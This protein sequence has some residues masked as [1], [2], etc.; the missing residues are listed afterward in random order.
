MTAQ[1]QT[2]HYVETGYV[3]GWAKDTFD[4]YSYLASH[5]DLLNAFGSNGTAATRHYAMNGYNAGRATDNF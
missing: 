4:E 5:I 1:R 2:Q 3:E